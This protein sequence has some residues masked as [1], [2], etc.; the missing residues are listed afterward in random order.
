MRKFWAVVLL[1][2]FLLIPIN[3][4]AFHVPLEEVGKSTINFLENSNVS[5]VSYQIFLR[6]RS[7]FTSVN[8]SMVLKNLNTEA[9]VS[10]L[11][12][13]PV[14]LDSITSVRDLS[15]VSNNKAINY[16]Q[17]NISKDATNENIANIS[18]WYTWEIS[19]QPGESKII[20]CAFSMDNKTDLDGTKRIDIP[21]QLLQGWAGQISNVQIIADLDFYPPYVFEPNPSIIPLEYDKDGR[22]TWRFKDVNA[23]ESKLSIFF[24]PIETVVLNYC[25]NITSNEQIV[26]VLNLFETKDYHG[27]IQQIDQLLSGEIDPEISS[28]SSELKFIQAICYKELYQLDKALERFNEI[29]GNVGFG[30][31]LSNAIRNKII[32]DKTMILKGLHNGEEKA[33][34]YL[35]EVKPSVENNEVFLIWLNDEIK[36]LTPE[37]PKVEETKDKE[38]SVTENNEGA[39][40][41]DEEEKI[42]KSI[43]IFGYEIPI[44]VLVL[45][46]ILFIIIIIIIRSRRKRRRNRYSIFR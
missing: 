39:K 6:V 27:T 43:D 12:G 11:M 31:T 37:P 36:R 14:Q 13:I 4:Y 18:K 46:I 22:I 20:E 28:L 35:N 32:Y 3:C 21:L 2:A 33:L 5:L 30:G 15:V 42:V 23:F 44:E 19:L 38:E 25:K 9:P 8:T 26:A 17:R 7:G 10:F 41:E 24:K 1:M 40:T 29:E 34:A 45:I 16:K